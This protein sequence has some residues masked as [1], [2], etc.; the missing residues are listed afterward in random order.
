MYTAWMFSSCS[1][2][3]CHALADAVVNMQGS[4]LAKLKANIYTVVTA[5]YSRLVTAYLN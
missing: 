1:A 5:C 3:W 4:E 2:R